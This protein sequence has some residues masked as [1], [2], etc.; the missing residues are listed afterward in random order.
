MHVRRTAQHH[1]AGSPAR[2][3]RDTA[4]NPLLA[5]QRSAGNRA[6]AQ[7]VREPSAGTGARTPTLQRDVTTATE[8]TAPASVAETVGHVSVS[9]GATMTGEA[10]L[11]EVYDKG[12][13]EITK[14]ALEMIDDGATVDEAARW[15][16]EA[17]N[18]L[19]V[20]IRKT[21]SPITKGV[22]EAR[23]TRK[24]GNKVGPSYDDLIRQGK[25]PMDVIGD[26]GKASTKW[27]KGAMKL[28]VGGPLLIV[29]DVAIVTW[30][31]YEAEENERLRTAVRGAGGVAGAL[32]GGW[33]GA[34]AGAWIGGG[35]GALFGGVGAPV[36][37]AI[38][39]V[40]GGVAG[41]IVGGSAGKAAADPVY[42]F[43]E[44]LVTPNLDAQLEAIDATQ[45]A[46]IRRAA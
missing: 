4:V 30:E 10:I 22:A 45:D 37:A 17:R 40:I 41:A 25:T 15:A 23:N 3:A 42:D 11:R 5:L 14:K 7:L 12:A 13:Q 31:V 1:A 2:A 39:G 38:G 32:G 34:K 20:D 26:S 24:Y 21:G 6:V 36:G 8:N 29:V 9:A 28:R 16:S 27:N 33:A 46:I 19:K 18:E 43:V 35:V 44:D